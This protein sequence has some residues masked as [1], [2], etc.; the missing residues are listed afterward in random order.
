MPT[1]LPNIL[2]SPASSRDPI[3]SSTFPAC[4]VS[5]RNPRIKTEV[6]PSFPIRIRLRFQIRR[7]RHSISHSPANGCHCHQTN[8]PSAPFF[9][10][11]R[12][13]SCTPLF[14]C[15]FVFFHPPPDIFTHQRASHPNGLGGGLWIFTENA[16]GLSPAD[17]NLFLGAL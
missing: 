10:A 15:L 17:H 12:C 9:S 14:V 1:L 2:S 5:H 7:R 6:G 3:P 4:A 8:C 16:S 13:E 11:N